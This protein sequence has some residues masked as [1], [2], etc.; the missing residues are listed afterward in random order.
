MRDW[1]VE[2]YDNHSGIETFSLV[3]WQLITAAC[4]LAVLFL[5]SL[6]PLQYLISIMTTTTQK[7]DG[8]EYRAVLNGRATGMRLGLDTAEI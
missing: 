8:T 3:I 4:T 6:R 2:G 7:Y 5:S 1:E